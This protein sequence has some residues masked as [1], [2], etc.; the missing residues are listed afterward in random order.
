MM[1]KVNNYFS[2]KERKTTLWEMIER[3]WIDLQKLRWQDLIK[4]KKDE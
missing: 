2:W 3:T 1:I 4:K